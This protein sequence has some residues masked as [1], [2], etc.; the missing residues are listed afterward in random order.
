VK[1]RY[2]VLTGL[3]WLTLGITDVSGR[4]DIGGPVGAG[5]LVAA[6]IFAVRFLLRRSQRALAARRST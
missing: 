2:W 1:R 3:A 5:L 4:S 6:V